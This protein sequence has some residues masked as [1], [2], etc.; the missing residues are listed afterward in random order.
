MRVVVTV[1]SR[2][3][4][5]PDGAVWTR[6][7][8]DQRFFA[9]Y[10]SAFDTVRVAARVTDVAAVGEDARRVDGDGIEVWPVPYYVGPGQFLLRRAAVGRAMRTAADTEDAVIVRAPS[11]IGALLAAAR[12]HAGLPYAVEVTGDPFDVFAPGV[13]DHPLRPLLRWRQTAVLQHQCRA[14][15]AV[16]YVTESYL[17]ARYPASPAAVTA[18]YSSVELPPEAYVGEPRDEQRCRGAR[19]LISVG[20]LEQR[21]KG[22]DTLIR[23]LAVLADTGLAAQ[24]LHVGDGRCRP[25]LEQLAAALGTT[26]HV[27]FVGTLSGSAAVRAVLDAADLFVMP[28]RTEGLPRALIEAMARGL[29]AVGTAVG[30]IPE[31]LPRSDLVQPDDATGL[32]RMIH[33]HL[34]DPA[35]MAAASARN[36]AAAR[37]YSAAELARRRDE[38]YRAVREATTDGRLVRR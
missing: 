23:A 32:A 15:A 30:G 21:Y 3:A 5:T 33:D 11:P 18:H 24:L 9:R 7:G 10:R 16:A 6:H 13:V 36:L 28:S 19:T 37:S 27:R 34:T 26:A 35:R 8:P 2:Y 20:S 38:F 14:A 25:Q 1:E 4:R 29:P 17:Q 22:I 31:L 12:R